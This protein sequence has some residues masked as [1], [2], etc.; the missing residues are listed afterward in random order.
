M[1]LSANQLA[2][3]EIFANP[4]DKRSYEE[5]AEEIGVHKNT[6]YNW[7]KDSDFIESIYDRFMSM[8]ANRL[9]TVINSMLKQGESGNVNAA[10]LMLEHYGKFKPELIVHVKDELEIA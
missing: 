1:S 9:P 7:Q 2:A 6:I 4:S 10:K 8:S 5:I 3:V